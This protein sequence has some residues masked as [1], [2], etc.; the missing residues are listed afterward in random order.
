MCLALK[1]SV[2]T[3]VFG[4]LSEASVTCFQVNACKLFSYNVLRY[5]APT[6]SWHAEECPTTIILWSWK[7]LC[8]SICLDVNVSVYLHCRKLRRWPHVCGMEQKDHATFLLESFTQK[9]WTTYW[10]CSPV[11]HSLSSKWFFAF[12]L[13]DSPRISFLFSLC[14]V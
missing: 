14:F 9:L 8:S 4:E 11:T 3:L 10:S 5:F 1:V 2:L 7:I 13:G 6:T 12:G